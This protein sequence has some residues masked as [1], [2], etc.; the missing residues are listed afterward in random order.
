MAT[1][2]QAIKSGVHTVSRPEVVVRGAERR[3]RGWLEWLATTDHKKIG[4]MYLVATFVFFLL[5]GVEALIMRLQL[6]AAGN[7]LV[8]GETYNGLVSMHGTTMIFLFVVPVL[9]GFGELPRAADDRRARHGVPAPERA[10]LLAAPVRRDRL[11]REPLLRAAD[12]RLDQLRPPLGRRLPT[13]R[14]D[15]RLDLPDPPHRPV[16][17]PRGD[18]LHRDDPQHARARH[19]L[20]PHAAVHLDDPDLRVPAGAR[21]PGGGGGGDDAAHRPAL[22]H[23]RSSRPPEAGTR[24]CGSTCSGSSGTPRCT[25]WSC[26]PSG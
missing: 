5:G 11:L 25:S 22:R 7:T 15:R 3:P 8:E 14:R 4:I 2:E 10:V 6:G 9:A 18:Q 13:R 19:G 23:R 26:P 1:P 24:C 20:G 21:A 12:G 16:V 17:D